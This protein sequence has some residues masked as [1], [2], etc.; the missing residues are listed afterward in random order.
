MGKKEKIN[1]VIND[2]YKI[3]F[4]SSDFNWRYEN[5]DHIERT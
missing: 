1:N 4:T 3:I 5:G 2:S